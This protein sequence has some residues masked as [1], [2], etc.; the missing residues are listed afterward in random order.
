MLPGTIDLALGRSTSCTIEAADVVPTQGGN[1]V[2]LAG[3]LGF[4]RAAGS[5]LE[6]IL[7]LPRISH[8]ALPHHR[9]LRALPSKSS[10]QR[11]GLA[12]RYGVTLRL[13]AWRADLRPG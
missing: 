9:A 13:G 12:L 5:L 8:P 7:P 1:L 10:I 3:S 11:Y 2:A 6:G 4:C